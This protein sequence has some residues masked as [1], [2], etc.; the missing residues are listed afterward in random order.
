MSK[1]LPK[2]TNSNLIAQAILPSLLLV[3]TIAIACSAQELPASSSSTEAVQ[4]TTVPTAVA[5]PK[6]EDIAMHLDLSDYLWENRLLLI[7]APSEATSAYRQQMQI[8]ADAQAGFDERDLL[9]IELLVDGNNRLNGEPV[10][11]EDAASV[12]SR[13]GI[14]NNDFVVMLIGKD[15]TQKRRDT[16]PVAAEAIFSAIDAMPM[17]QQ[18]MRQ[19]Q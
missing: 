8:F 4:E 10:A 7:F 18:E 1:N 13:Y 12:R 15:G 2:M 11:E 14:A 19:Q 9:L 16:E 17:R 6:V 3:Q 5:L